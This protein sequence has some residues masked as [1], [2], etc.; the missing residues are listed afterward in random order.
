MKIEEITKKDLLSVTGISYGQLYRWKRQGLIPEDW[1]IK[2]ASFT[3]QETYFPKD[4]ILERID[5]ILELKDDRSLEEISDI[6]NNSANYSIVKIE[7][8]KNQEIFINEDVLMLLNKDQLTF[9]EIVILKII[10]NIYSNDVE[11]DK[12]TELQE[13]LIKNKKTIIT[14]EYEYIYFIIKNGEIGCILLKD[15]PEVEYNLS[16]VVKIN[17]KNLIENLKLIIFV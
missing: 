14:N 11:K 5:K 16:E 12:I 8:I 15:K 6:I 2:R 1:F 10:D 7:A 4:L 17:L 9:E 13:F 3:G